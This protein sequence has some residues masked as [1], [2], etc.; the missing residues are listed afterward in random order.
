MSDFWIV[1]YPNGDRNE[2]CLAQIVEGLEHEVEDYDLASR[3]RFPNQVD[4]DEYGRGLAREHSKVWTN[5][6]D[7]GILD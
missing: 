3:K 7:D 4:A 6:R 2:M 1:I 5:G